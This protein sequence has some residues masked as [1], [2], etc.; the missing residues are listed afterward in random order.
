MRILIWTNHSSCCADTSSLSQKNHFEYALKHGYDIMWEYCS[1]PELMDKMP[2]L[3]NLLKL[4]DAV[5]MLDADTFITNPE[6]RLEDICA[7]GPDV[8]MCEEYLGPHSRI[9][10]GV[11]MLNNTP[12]THR[13]L[14]DINEAKPEWINSTHVWQTWVN[15]RLDSLPITLLH[16][17][18][19][20]SIV[21]GKTNYWHK[22]DFIVH[23]AGNVNRAEMMKE[24][25]SSLNQ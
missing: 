12:A 19:F 24:F 8:V 20:N 4:Y 1:Y 14:M 6:K 9:N 21:C 25:Y 23:F 17:K 3:S 13:F 11:V 10:M 5:F 15:A 7:M 22:G 18:A 16:G 2:K